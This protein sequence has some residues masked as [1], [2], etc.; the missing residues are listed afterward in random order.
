ML[1]EEYQLQF[2]SD[3]GFIR[4]QCTE[5]GKHFWTRDLERKTCGDA[6]CD[7]YTFIGE[8][9]F[10]KP[11]ELA[12]MREYYLNFFESHDH[13]RLERYPVVARWR[14]D[15][16]LTIASIADFQP[17][18]TSGQVPPPA[19]PLTISQPCIRLSDLDAVGRSGRHLT[20]FEMMAHHAFNTKKKEIYWKDETV[21]LCDELLSSLGADPLA[22]TYK[23]EPWAGG[24][25]AGPCLEALI[26]GLEVATLVFMNLQ[27]SKTGQVELKGDRYSVMDNNYIVD[28]GYGLERFVWASK[29]SP[30]IYDAIFPEIVNEIMGLAGIEHELDNS[31]YSNIL[32]QNARLAGMIDISEKANLFELRKKVA[33]NI[34]IPV[35]RLAAIMEPVETVYSITDHTRCLTFML[36]DGIIP[37]NVKAGY[38]AR[39]V[40]RRT[41]RMLR[42]LDV[43]IP[44]C[45]IVQMHIKNLPE[46]PEFEEKMDVI[47]DILYHEEQKFSE[48]LDRGR[49]MILKSAQHYRKKDEKIPLEKLI[50]L[51]DSHG[52]PPEITK[53]IAAE[54]DVEVSLPD[55]FYSLVA[56][57]HS[58]APEREGEEGDVEYAGRLSGLPATKKLFYDDPHRMEFEAVVLD[59]FDNKIVL[60]STFM[61]PEGGG[62]PADHGIMMVEDQLLDIVDVQQV[63]DVIVH[64]TG[65][66]ENELHV[67]K[68]DI[69]TVRIDEE[70]RS[71]HAAHHTA[72]HVVIDAARKVLGDHI[73][74]MGAQKAQ[75]RARLD[76]SHYKRISQEELDRIELV[77]N[78]IVMKNTRVTAE[79]MERVEAERTYGFRLYQGGVPPGKKIR[80]L[81]VGDDVEACAG[82]HL[83]STGNVGPI[84]ILRTE[85]I[86]DGVERLEFAAGEAAVRAMQ[87]I[88]SLLARSA[89][90]LR[91]RPEHL[92]ATIERFFGEWKELKK[93]NERL[94]EEL[95]GLRVYQLMQES[96]QISGVQVIARKI[97]NADT[98]ELMKIA[99][100]I[101]RNDNMVAVLA[102]DADGIRIVAAAGK[103]AV[104]MGVDCGAIVRQA[105]GIAGGGGG[106]KP[107]MAQGGGSDLSKIDDAIA[108]GVEV[109]RT[110]LA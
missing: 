4:K 18:V 80:V 8:P 29:G 75:D 84:R 51:Y 61:Y 63:G 60:D 99:G 34:G 72:T 30:T 17:F 102:G 101:S 50:E 13:T 54:E 2:F 106:G 89:E 105:S 57:R 100:Q 85:R 110:Q 40:T 94:T 9:V 7:P 71:A 107:G 55:N 90:A 38:L 31:E 78:R 15:I 64:I 70:R 95:A 28:T 32:A 37:S 69:V 67:R 24:G 97:E 16:Y 3:N 68:G 82:T 79:W 86:Q 43:K 65:D 77:A 93:E 104:E 56:S 47:E 11:F 36:G 25:N 76:L 19:N 62:Q 81:K 109:I 10:R 58:S 6:P 1:E 20:T 108:A 39:L 12:D 48:T 103:A 83:R 42:D 5:C 49:R 74:Q 73:W 14:D 96:E 88:S 44:I 52:I 98:G 91:V 21:G 87:N 59:M 41:L 92:P 27:K 53:E 46:Y 23:E 26:G 66:I 35:D 22:V 45:E 33:S